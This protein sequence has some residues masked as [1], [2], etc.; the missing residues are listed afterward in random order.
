MVRKFSGKKSQNKNQMNN[1]KK[2]TGKIKINK[3]NIHE[4]KE[5]ERKKKCFFVNQRL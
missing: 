3:N 1:R 4:E 5:K 2:A